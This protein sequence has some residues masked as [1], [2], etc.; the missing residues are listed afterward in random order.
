MGI[1]LEQE[2][3]ATLDSR[4]RHEHRMLDGKKVPVGEKFEIDGYEIAFPG[5]PNGEPEMV[6]NCR[7][8]L[9]PALKGFEVDV[10]DT[11]LRHSDKMDEETYDEWKESHNITSDSITKQDDI[12]ETMEREYGK[13]YAELAGTK[14]TPSDD[15]VDF[16]DE[17]LT[18][19]E[20]E[21]EETPKSSEDIV[22]D[23]LAESYENHRLSNG[24]DATPLSDLDENHFQVYFTNMDETLKEDITQ[25]LEYLTSKYDTT[26]QS[27]LPMSKDEYALLGNNFASTIHDYTV[28]SSRVLYNPVKIKDVDRI[29]ENIENGFCTSINLKY[30]DRY[31]ITHEFA[32][33]LLDMQTTLNNKTNW[34]GADY[35]KIKSARSEIT[36]CYERYIKEREDLQ[37]AFNEANEKAFK[38]MDDADMEK[39]DKLLDELHKVD[40]GEYSLANSDEFMAEGFTHSELGGEP[41]KYADEIKSI[42]DK[43]FRR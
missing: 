8:T 42:I 1:G 9:I 3:L 25:Q 27:F 43:Y 19:G 6:Y 7:C 29:I 39:A 40:L 31:V 13:E 17:N 20:K 12:A 30:A 37:K 22:R 35:N 4:T 2:W 5:D 14:Y 23:C 24:L 41:N 18:K 33:T 11:S 34:L 21:I 36:N 32:H 28:D 15:S 38:T 10:S 16:E 26:M